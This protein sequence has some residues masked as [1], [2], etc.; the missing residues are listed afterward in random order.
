[1]RRTVRHRQRAPET[2]RPIDMETAL[3]L[4]C[5]GL[6]IRRIAHDMRCPVLSLLARISEM[7]NR[8]CQ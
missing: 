3:F 7:D 1:M 8:F 4:W 2:E 6:S 5:K